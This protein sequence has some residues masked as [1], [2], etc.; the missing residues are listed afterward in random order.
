MKSIYCSE[1]E[2]WRELLLACQVEGV[3]LDNFPTTSQK[4]K[5]K[6]SPCF[7][8]ELITRAMT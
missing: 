7:R 5:S 6:I 1:H 3:P 8:E 4:P 2:K